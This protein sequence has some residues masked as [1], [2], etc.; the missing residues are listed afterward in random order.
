MKQRGSTSGLIL[1]ALALLVLFALVGGDLPESVILETVEA[2]PT[3]TSIPTANQH[4]DLWRADGSGDGS[5]RRKYNTTAKVNRY[6]L[7]VSR[8]C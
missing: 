1:L 3:D 7:S 2:M 4:A 8:T 6:L 5:V